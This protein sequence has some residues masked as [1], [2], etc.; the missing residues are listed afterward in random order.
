[1]L[2]IPLAC[3]PPKTRYAVILLCPVSPILLNFQSK[4]FALADISTYSLI[5]A[6]A[7]LKG[8]AKKV[9]CILL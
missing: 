5:Q 8:G 6:S 2:L 7:H 1:M 9:R 4:Q 3:S